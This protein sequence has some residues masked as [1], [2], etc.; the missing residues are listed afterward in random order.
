MAGVR[1]ETAC[2]DLAQALHRD[3]RPWYGHATVLRLTKQEQLAAGAPAA[4]PE[5]PHPTRAAPLC[6]HCRH[7]LPDNFDRSPQRAW[8]IHPAAA[9][10]PVD[11]SP[12]DR[13]VHM[14]E[15]N[16]KHAL[17]LG[18][19]VCGPAGNLFAPR[20]CVNHRA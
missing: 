8:C 12:A 20:E 6:Q 2:L 5:L 13:A 16:P 11:G 3:W 17:Q 10:N 15:A 19:T 7:C 14:R 9:V 1:G 4:T 18:V